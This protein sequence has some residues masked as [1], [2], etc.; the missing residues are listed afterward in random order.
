MIY[1]SVDHAFADMNERIWTE[2]KLKSEELLPAVD[3]AFALM[4]AELDAAEKERILA[5]AAEVRAVL[6]TEPH[7]ANRLKRANQALD[8]A[9]EALAARI[10]ERAY[11][12][13]LARSS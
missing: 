12:E 8:E 5:A 1:E 13:A 11:A 4:G 6:A 7:D 9:T 2:A 10:V 3:A